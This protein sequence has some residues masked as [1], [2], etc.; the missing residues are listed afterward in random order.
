MSKGPTQVV[1]SLKSMWLACSMATGAES[2]VPC[3]CQQAQAGILA[4]AGLRPWLHTVT[5][6]SAVEHLTC[7]QSPALPC[8]RAPKVQAE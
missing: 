7:L 6:P 3:V 4:A 1:P 5:P 8:T 2:A